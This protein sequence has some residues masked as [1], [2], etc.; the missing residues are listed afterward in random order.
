MTANVTISTVGNGA[1]PPA[2]MD[3]GVMGE[4]FGWGCGLGL[5]A[6]DARVSTWICECNGSDQAVRSR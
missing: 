4:H 2:G 5:G 1:A 6:E 3:G